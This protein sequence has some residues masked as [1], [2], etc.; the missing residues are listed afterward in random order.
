MSGATSAFPWPYWPQQSPINLNLDDSI[1][2]DF[3]DDYFDHDYQDAPFAGKFE[4]EAGHANFVLTK[5]HPGDHAPRIVVGGKRAELVKIHLHTPSEHDLEG[6]DYTGEIHLIHQLGHPLHNPRLIVL[7]VFF[8]QDIPAQAGQFFQSWIAGQAAHCNSARSS[9]GGQADAL[10]IDPC[11]LIPK[12]KHREFFRYEGSLT[13]SPYTENVSWL[14]FRE[15]IGITSEDFEA[16]RE[17]AHQ[18]ERDVQHQA[19][20]FVLRNFGPR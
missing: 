9:S 19:R 7:G 14:V 4:G 3:G 16:I 1:R 10:S 12:K 15:P 18:P 20:R 2:V 8:A 13:S 17:H 5:P 11:N 6:H